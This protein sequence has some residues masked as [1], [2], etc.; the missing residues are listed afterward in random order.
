M[1]L[2]LRTSFRA[3]R[4]R[5]RRIL[6]L[7][8]LAAGAG[9]LGSY[10]I[11]II[12]DAA[13]S[14]D[15]TRALQ[16]S[17]V[18]AVTVAVAMFAQV[19][20]TRMGPALSERTG[21]LVDQQLVELVSALAPIDDLERPDY[22]DRLGLLQRDGQVLASAGVDISQGLALL[23]SGLLATVLLAPVNPVLVAL[24]LF[25]LPALW[26]GSRVE[27]VRQAGLAGVDG[28]I[29]EGRH[30]FDLSTS[31]RAAKDVRVGGLT[32]ELIVRHRR[33]GVQVGWILDRLSV[34]DV[35]WAGWCRL[36]F[37]L[38]FG[39]ALAVVVRD[40]VAGTATV[41][42]VALVLALAAQMNHRMGRAS[43]A[44]AVARTARVA[45]A[46]LWLTAYSDERARALARPVTVPNRLA[47]GIEL[48]GV[49]FRYPG[50]DNDVL[51]DVDLALPAGS[52]VALVG[53]NGSGKSTIVKLICRL[54][55]PSRGAVLVEGVDLRRIEG[56]AWQARMSVSLSES[57]SADHSAP[58][59]PDDG[60]RPK[61]SGHQQFSSP[62]PVVVEG[63]P[64]GS[65]AIS[66]AP[67]D[68]PLV[69]LF[70]GATD[71]HSGADERAALADHVAVGRAGGR[72][73]GAVT[74]LVSQGFSGPML[75]D[76]VAVIDDGRVVETG[77]HTEL[78]AAG[79]LYSRLYELEA[80]AYR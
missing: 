8:L 48:C 54:Y 41:G 56:D 62:A 34:L 63:A 25:A 39:G 31:V 10:A 6:T 49:G 22:L 43:S 33:L 37:S 36:F 17:L 30:L 73:N 44:N 27:Q 75:A 9:G 12:I 24:G 57:V 1:A 67:R 3:D 66:G 2:A 13:E 26:A 47:K 5:T 53:E 46:Y 4:D 50:E 42:D 79:G 80:R 74:L 61:P 60:G 72:R 35:A 29:Q 40:V 69:F 55:P 7:S 18:V 58:E 65:F 52:V 38:A 68:A 21:R 28:D 32:K 19:A 14:G 15:E 78:L 51:I 45:A 77:T 16:G 23:A 76:L 70:E 20:V 59:W 64:A 11:K 71:S